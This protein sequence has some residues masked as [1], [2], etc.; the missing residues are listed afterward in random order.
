[1]SFNEG[2]DTYLGQGGVNLSGGQKQRIAIARAIIKEPKLLILDDSTSAL[3]MITEKQ[4][5]KELKE[6]L[7]NTTTIMIAQRITSVMDAD[8]ILV[9]DKGKIV[10]IGTHNELMKNSKTYIDI[11]HSQIGKEVTDIGS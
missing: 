9:M 3:D 7:K 10:S 1:M 4:I 2:Y 8:K 11:Y 5:K 6:H